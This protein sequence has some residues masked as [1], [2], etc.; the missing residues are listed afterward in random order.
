MVSVNKTAPHSM[1]TKTDRRA[2]CFPIEEPPS[3]HTLTSIWLDTFSPSRWTMFVKRSADILFSL[4]GLILCAPVLLLCA[5]VIRL[6]SPGPVFYRQERLTRNEQPFQIYKF[7]TMIHE[8]EKDTGCILASVDDP[9]ITHAG[10]LLRAVHLDELPQ[11]FNV[12]K[13]EMSLVGPRPERPHFVKEYKKTVNQ[14]QRRFSVR[15]GMTGV[16]QV[17]GHYY[18]NAADKTFYDLWYLNHFSIWQDIAL[19]GMTA[20][21]LLG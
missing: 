2:D 20:K 19:I 16:A 21:H 10:K 11:L 8:A 12:L 13:G 6:D 1:R 7:R 5:V 4:F 3:L 17:Y 14:Y 9:R 15:A 18:T